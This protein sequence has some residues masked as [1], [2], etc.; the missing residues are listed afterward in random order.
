MYLTARRGEQAPDSWHCGCDNRPGGDH[1]YIFYR[2]G[3]GS[4]GSAGRNFARGHGIV[5]AEINPG[6][7]AEYCADYCADYC[8][9]HGETRR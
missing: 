8:T 1:P 9:G 4:P 7:S 3:A 5:A 6:H 2:P